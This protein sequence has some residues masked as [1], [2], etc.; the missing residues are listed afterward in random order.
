[1]SAQAVNGGLVLKL[2]II[3]GFR[4]RAQQCRVVP[5]ATVPD[6]RGTRTLALHDSSPHARAAQRASL[7]SVASSVEDDRFE[8]PLQEGESRR[9]SV[10]LT[11]AAMDAMLVRSLTRRKSR[12]NK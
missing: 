4:P 9:S 5:T 11:A 3:V 7:L 10:S 1:M 8:T 2:N 6:W 12:V